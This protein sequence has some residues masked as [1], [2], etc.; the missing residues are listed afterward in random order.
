MTLNIW[1]CF[2]ANYSLN[3]NNNLF[4]NNYAALRGGG[5]YFYQQLPIVSEIMMNKFKTN[6][7]IYGNDFASYPI[8]ISILSC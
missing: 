2:K 1:I 6:Y 5:L 8:R 7:A 3:L 4:D